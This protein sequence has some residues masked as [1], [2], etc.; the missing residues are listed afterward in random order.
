[1]MVL[2]IRASAPL[3]QYRFLRTFLPNELCALAR[4]ELSW[5]AYRQCDYER[6][7]MLGTCPQLL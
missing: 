5:L 2:G 4:S 1:M 3:D 7:M 6:T